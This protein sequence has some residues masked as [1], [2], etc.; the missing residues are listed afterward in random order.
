MIISVHHVYKIW[1]HIAWFKHRAPA[2]IYKKN[3]KYRGYHIYIWSV[4]SKIDLLHIC[5]LYLRES[6]I[7]HLTF[8][9]SFKIYTDKSVLY[10][11]KIL[12][13]Q[14]MIFNTKLS[15][16]CLGNDTASHTIKH[17]TGKTTN[18]LRKVTTRIPTCMKQNQCS[19]MITTIYMVNYHSESTWRQGLSTLSMVM[20]LW[21]QL[22]QAT[23]W[24]MST[25]SY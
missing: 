21:Y 5:T 20:N 6:F 19:D 1:E 15:T 3:W 7:L 10:H 14:W 8:P 9:Y 23:L 16:S 18:G 17:N 12:L 24:N 22:I 25:Q 11:T 13:Y 4:S 2:K